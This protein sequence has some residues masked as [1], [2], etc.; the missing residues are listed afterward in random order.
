MVSMVFYGIHHK[1]SKINDK[2]LLH[3]NSGTPLFEM[4][5]TIPINFCGTLFT[6]ERLR[7]V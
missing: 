7:F 2:R 4:K 6:S 1:R 5:G 3:F